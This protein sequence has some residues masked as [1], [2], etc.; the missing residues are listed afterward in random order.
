MKLTKS[1]KNHG[2]QLRE[3][4]RFL[5]DTLKNHPERIADSVKLKGNT[6]VRTQNGRM[7]ELETQLVDMYVEYKRL[8]PDMFETKG[9]I[10]SRIADVKIMGEL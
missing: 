8:Y 5:E 7:K 3:G 9:S 4:I 6:I 2:R 1:Q 10:Y